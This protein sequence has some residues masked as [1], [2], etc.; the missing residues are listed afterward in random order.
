MATPVTG[1]GSHFVADL[2][3]ANALLV[4]PSETA[5][6]DAG[7]RVQLILLDGEECLHVTR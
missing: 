6:L 2:S 5:S 4:I 1:Q 3:R 7:D